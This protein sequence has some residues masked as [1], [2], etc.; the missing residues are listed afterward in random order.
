MVREEEPVIEAYD[1]HLVIIIIEDV[2]KYDK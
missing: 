2:L 1:S